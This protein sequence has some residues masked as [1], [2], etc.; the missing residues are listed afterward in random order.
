M[1]IP[2]SGDFEF[3]KTL[4]ANDFQEREKYQTDWNMAV[5]FEHR[6]P[7]MPPMPIEPQNLNESPMFSARKKKIS[8]LTVIDWEWIRMI[9]LKTIQTHEA[10]RI[11]ERQEMIQGIAEK[12]ARV[13]YT[14]QLDNQKFRI[15]MAWLERFRAEK[16]HKQLRLQEHIDFMEE[17]QHRRVN[18]RENQRIE[19][20]LVRRQRG[21]ES[22]VP[23]PP[24]K[25]SINAVKAE[26]EAREEIND[27][28]KTLLAFFNEN[29]KLAQ[30]QV[31]NLLLKKQISD[32]FDHDNPEKFTGH[33]GY[34]VHEIKSKK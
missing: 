9:Q 18:T 8:E 21:L 11:K 26:L 1:K 32:Q 19:K 22:P 3:H 5:Q 25:L 24:P 2:K 23:P 34:V 13:W 20:F 30:T 12:D 31:A 10:K 17:V 29:I 6:F 7:M 4:D 16:R 14:Y 28:R 27:Q 15:Y 33:G